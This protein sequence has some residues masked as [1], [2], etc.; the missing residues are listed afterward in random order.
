MLRMEINACAF[1]HYVQERLELAFGVGPC[2]HGDS[3]EQVEED[4]T[5]TRQVSHDI[6]YPK[7]DRLGHARICCG[8]GVLDYYGAAPLLDGASAHGPLRARAGAGSRLPVVRRIPPR[9]C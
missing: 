8:S 5:D 6:H 4:R 7:F 9:R 1:P 3:G 2:W